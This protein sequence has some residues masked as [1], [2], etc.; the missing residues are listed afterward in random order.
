MPHIVTTYALLADYYRDQYNLIC[1]L[2]NLI[3]GV[4]YPSTDSLLK[5]IVMLLETTGDYPIRI[6]ILIR[7]FEFIYRN[8]P[9]NEYLFQNRAYMYHLTN[10]GRV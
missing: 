9:L 8:S 3:Y 10:P 5:W 1:S 2:I 6:L 7:S 4:Q